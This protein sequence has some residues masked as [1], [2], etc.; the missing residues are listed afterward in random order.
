MEF[1]TVSPGGFSWNIR[2]ILNQSLQIF[3]Y[4]EILD[5]LRLIFFTA[6]NHIFAGDRSEPMLGYSAFFRIDEEAVLRGYEF[7]AVFYLVYCTA[8]LFGIEDDH[9][10]FA[11]R[12]LQFENLL[13][14]ESKFCFQ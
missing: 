7:L 4:V 9:I 11:Y 6:I 2:C 14:R 5:A 1:R 12:K 13:A 3:L 8:Q 10:K